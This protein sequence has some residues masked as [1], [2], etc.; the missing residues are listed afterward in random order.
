VDSKR[1]EEIK[2]EVQILL[3]AKSIDQC[4]RNYTEHVERM[5]SDTIPK[6][7]F[8][9]LTEKGKK[10]RK[11]SK[12]VEGFCFVKPVTGLSRPNSENVLFKKNVMH[13]EE[14]NC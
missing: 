10:F 1:K 6:E 13:I 4:R 5:S 3:T 11:A 14:K 9:I 8:K 2:R 12:M 7:D